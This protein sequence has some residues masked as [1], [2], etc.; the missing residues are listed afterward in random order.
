VSAR[1]AIDATKVYYSNSSG[2]FE[3]DLPAFA[4]T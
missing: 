1:F 3:T 2:V 4:P